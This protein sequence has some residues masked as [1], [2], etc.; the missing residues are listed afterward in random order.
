MAKDGCGNLLFGV[1][2]D[3]LDSFVEDGGPLQ[4]VL[5][6]CALV[7]AYSHDLVSWCK[8]KTPVVHFSKLFGVEGDMLDSFVEDGGPLQTFA[9]ENSLMSENVFCL[10]LGQKTNS[11]LGLSQKNPMC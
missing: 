8:I 2:G 1:E 3:M 4:T 9:L 11:K 10:I 7:A 6:M 5:C